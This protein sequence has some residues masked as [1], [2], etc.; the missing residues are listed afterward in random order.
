MEFVPTSDMIFFGS[1]NSENTILTTLTRLSAKRTSVFFR[2]EIYCSNLQ[3]TIMYYFNCEYS[4]INH[5][6]GMSDILYD[7]IFSQGCVG[8]IPCMRYTTLQSFQCLYL[9]QFSI[10][11]HVPTALSS[12]YTSGHCTAAVGFV[13]AIEKELLF[14][15]PSW[16]HHQSLPVHFLLAK[17]G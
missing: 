5:F 3:C 9:Y 17:S 2:T 16:Q 11:T 8:G 6:H 13:S 12:L 15:C 14:S 4:S 1:P 10:L 7:T